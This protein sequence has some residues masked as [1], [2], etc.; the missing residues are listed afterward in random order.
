MADASIN[1]K[2]AKLT[3]S[4]VHNE[5]KAEVHYAREDLKDQ[6]ETLVLFNISTKKKEIAAFCKEVTGRKLQKNAVPIRE[7]VI[8]IESHHTMKDLQNVASRIKEKLGIECFQIHIHRDEG[9]WVN[10]RGI[11]ISYKTRGERKQFISP[12]EKDAKWIPNLHAHMVFD[13]QEKDRNKTTIKKIRGKE[14]I[15]ILGGKPKK[16]INFSEAQDIASD[17][18]GMK[19][20]Q[21]KSNTNRKRLESVE[22]KVQQEEKS[23]K[24]LQSETQDLEQKKN[25]AKSRFEAASRANK[26]ARRNYKRINSANEE[27]RSRFKEQTE[28]FATNGI[29]VDWQII[30]GFPN[31]ISAAVEL[32]QEWLN[33]QLNQINKIEKEIRDIREKPSYIEQYASSRKLTE[34]IERI[35]EETKHLEKSI[36]SNS[37]IEKEIAELEERIKR[38]GQG[39]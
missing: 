21:R 27:F 33:I 17:V 29:T 6:N 18:L 24:L 28:K 5:R 23:L 2:A 39:H 20:G 38:Q 1:F 25:Q 4:E 26:E 11:T 3:S 15:V 14:K 36:Y 10:S 37:I 32:Q 22:Y 9:R 19:R 30:K 8:N 35:R 7:A 16:W 12:P 34:E 31:E 13:Y